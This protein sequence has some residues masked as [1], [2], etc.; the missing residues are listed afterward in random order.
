MCDV[1]DAF[2]LMVVHATRPVT[3][4]VLSAVMNPRTR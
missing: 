4:T 3:A 2:V 1:A